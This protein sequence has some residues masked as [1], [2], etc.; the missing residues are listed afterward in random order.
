MEE[1]EMKGSLRSFTVVMSVLFLFTITLLAQVPSLINYQGYLTDPGTNEP[2]TDSKSMTFSIYS[3]SSGGTALWTETQMVTIEDG[4]FSILL[5]STTP[6]SYSVFTGGDLYLGVT[7]DTDAEMTP[8]KRIVSVGYALKSHDADLLE[9]QQ[10]ADFSSSTHG[11][12]GSSWD[13]GSSTNIGLRLQGSVPWNNAIL[14]AQNDNNGPGIW[15]YNYGVGDGIRGS[16]FGSGLGV[17]GESSTGIAI[18]G[19]STDGHGVQGASTNGPGI[20]GM[21]TTGYGV[22]AKSTSNYGIYAETSNT[23]GNF[24]GYFKGNGGIQTETPEGSYSAHL[25]NAVRITRSGWHGIQIDNSSWAGIWVNNAGADGFEVT[26]AGDDGFSVNSAARHGFYV[27]SA[28]NNG[29]LIGSTVEGDAIHINGAAQHGIY[30]AGAGG[31]GVDVAAADGNGVQV[32]S[33]GMNGVAVASAT[34]SGVYVA[35]AGSDA[36]RVQT[37]G[38]DGLRFFEGVGRDY[39]RAGSDADLDFRVTGSGAAYADGGFNGA[40]DFAE[41]IVTE[42]NALSYEPGDVMAISSDVDRAVTLSTQ[43]YSTAIVGVYS[44]KPGFIGS[45]HPT[46]EKLDN[47]IPV[48]ITG[49]VPCKVTTE[50]GPIKRG[51]L[52]T[53]SS[54][55]GFAMKATAPQI[56][57]IL[58]KAMGTLNQ[59][60]GIIEILVVLQ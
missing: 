33:A 7:V 4:Y 55:P 60:S 53:S 40:A 20:E 18:K 44:T 36:I 49:I 34:W 50:N 51:D 13:G 3:V 9:G 43:P 41:L 39:I 52:L 10:A 27:N 6:V 26:T 56:G 54:K 32:Y 45:T 2:I 58:G 11:H 25:D 38:Q 59:G 46:T 16:N 30:I 24:A 23:G 35:S 21:S 31:Q 5:G 22:K 47:E 17:Y 19:E 42:G 12:W 1:F 8:R 28:N 14:Y 37:A 48:A 29:L 57:T 15:G